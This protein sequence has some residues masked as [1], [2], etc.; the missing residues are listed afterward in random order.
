MACF[1]RSKTP[2]PSL[3]LLLWE[4]AARSAGRRVNAQRPL[5]LSLSHK[6]R[7][8]ACPNP[9]F[10]SPDYAT[11]SSLQD[12]QA[13]RISLGVRILEAPAA[14]PLDAGGSAAGRGLPRLGAEAHQP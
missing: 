14:D 10:R 1:A 7:G 5:T 6:G 4:K 8:E 11:P 13:L 12:L 2:S 3:L 9:R